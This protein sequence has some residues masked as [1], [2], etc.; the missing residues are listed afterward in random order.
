MSNKLVEAA[1]EFLS[2]NTSSK[3]IISEKISPYDLDGHRQSMNYHNQSSNSVSK[4]HLND[5]HKEAAKAHKAAAD[6]IENNRPNA[7]E[8]SKKAKSMSAELSKHYNIT[9][10]DRYN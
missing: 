8:L 7:E 1:V 6:A 2:R 9:H 4:P 10:D 5:K 3:K